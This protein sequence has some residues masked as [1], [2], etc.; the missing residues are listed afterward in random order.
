MNITKGNTNF[1]LDAVANMTFDE[2]SDRYKGKLKGYDLKQAY[3]EMN[4]GKSIKPV[5]KA[6]KK[7]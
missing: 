1:N 3:K 6:N 7:K 2:F 4:G 5:K